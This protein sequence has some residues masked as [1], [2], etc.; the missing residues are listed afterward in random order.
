M[1]L[2]IR[3]RLQ[4]KRLSFEVK[5]ILGNTVLLLQKFDN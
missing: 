2:F 4:I 3:N 5:N 1:A